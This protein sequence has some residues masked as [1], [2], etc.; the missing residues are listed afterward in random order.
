[1]E[2]LNLQ[3]TETT[4]ERCLLTLLEWLSSHDSYQ[5]LEAEAPSLYKIQN[6]LF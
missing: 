3:E 4:Y 5:E 2:I 6:Q 1:M